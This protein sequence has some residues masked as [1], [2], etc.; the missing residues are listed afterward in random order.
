MHTWSQSGQVVVG[1]PFPIIKRI[2]ILKRDIR[3]TLQIQNHF[4]LCALDAESV[5]AGK[6]FGLELLVVKSV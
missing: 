1:L 5:R 6:T 4:Y 3:N 2:H